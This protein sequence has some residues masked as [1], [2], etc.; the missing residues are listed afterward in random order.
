VLNAGFCQRRPIRVT[1]TLGASLQYRISP[2]WRTEAS[3]E[4]V[5][6]CSGAEV[7][8]QNGLVARQLGLDLFWER[9]Y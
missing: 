2:E 3:F 4:P 7:D 9:R 6:S 8:A 1:N 5:R